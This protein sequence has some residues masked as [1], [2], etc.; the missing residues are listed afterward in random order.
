M[1]LIFWEW[2]G[3]PYISILVEERV[4]L[5]AGRGNCIR[6]T[7]GRGKDDREKDDREKDDREKDD[8]EKDV[9]P[10]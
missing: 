1:S 5:Y 9:V 7:D 4:Y 8:R 6:G 3:E 10:F 2:V